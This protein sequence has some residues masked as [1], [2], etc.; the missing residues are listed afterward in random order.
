MLLCTLAHTPVKHTEHCW[1]QCCTVLCGWK[2][3]G[4]FCFTCEHSEHVTEHEPQH[5]FPQLRSQLLSTFQTEDLERPRH[6][7]FVTWGFKNFSA[8]LV[9]VN[10]WELGG[11][12]DHNMLMMH[13][14]FP[15]RLLAG[16]HGVEACCALSVHPTSRTLT[17]QI[18]WAVNVGDFCSWEREREGASSLSASSSRQ[19]SAAGTWAAT[20]SNVIM[21]EVTH[22]GLLWQTH[23]SAACQQVVEKNLS[24]EAKHRKLCQYEKIK[25]RLDTQM[26][27]VGI[28]Q[29]EWWW[30]SLC[31]NRVG[32][33]IKYSLKNAFH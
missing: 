27:L 19:L 12:S 9:R 2:V 33:K 31:E 11:Q 29:E 13:L 1:S 32:W 23:L 5:F 8:D 26:R 21:S 6:L 7:H 18:T 4:V 28:L 30:V 10:S 14:V 24:S 22:Q 16:L 3:S 15:I 25:V 17:A 20:E